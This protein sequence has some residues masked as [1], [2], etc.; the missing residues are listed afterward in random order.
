MDSR[1]SSIKGSTRGNLSSVEWIEADDM[2][3][4]MLMEVLMRLPFKVLFKFKTVSKQWCSMISCPSFA[5]MYVDRRSR[6]PHSQD[7]ILVSSFADKVMTEQFF[8]KK[9]PLDGSS[10]GI[11]C[12]DLLTLPCDQFHGFDHVV[13]GISNGLLLYGPRLEVAKRL[14]IYS[15]EICN[16]I[17]GQRITLPPSE[18]CFE[19]VATGFVTQVEDNVLQSYKVVRIEVHHANSGFI[20]FDVYSSEIREWEYFRIHSRICFYK[21]KNPVV[22]GKIMHWMVATH[23][24]MAFDPYN[25][26][27]PPFI[28]LISLPSDDVASYRLRKIE[29]DHVLLDEHQGHLR[30]VEVKLDG[31]QPI[32]LSIWELKDYDSGR[33][34]LQHRVSIDELRIRSVPLSFHPFDSNNILY[35][36][37]YKALLSF[38]VETGELKVVDDSSENYIDKLPYGMSYFPFVIPP[39]PVFISPS[40]FEV[41]H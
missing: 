32:K 21:W 5:R 11:N 29:L 23:S 30:Y 12:L 36:I 14:Q 24:V 22:L 38:D 28:S 19:F 4:W 17:T 34:C 15:Y 8:L 25:I 7:W 10:L 9:L 6:S 13:V 18:S 35:L 39:W 41:T 27:N 31:R 26:N 33:W 2:P 3:E 16:P 40:L 20:R 1:R 37:N